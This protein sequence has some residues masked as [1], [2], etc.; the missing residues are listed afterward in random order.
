MIPKIIERKSKSQILEPMFMLQLSS[1]SL[2]VGILLDRIHWFH[3]PN[4][5]IKH[6]C[7]LMQNYN[8]Q[9]IRSKKI[10]NKRPVGSGDTEQ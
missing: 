2:M 9:L 3:I 5:I 4:F 1:L 7:A 8:M 10:K 6:S